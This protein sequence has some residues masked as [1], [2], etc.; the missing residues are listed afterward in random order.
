MASSVTLMAVFTC[1]EKLIA[2]QFPATGKSRAQKNVPVAPVARLAA[3]PGQRLVTIS[4]PREVL[5][6]KPGEVF[7][8]VSKIGQSAT[9]ELTLP[10]KRKKAY[11]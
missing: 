2:L 3:L 8:A 4:A 5:D 11:E 6:M 9:A 10:P 7:A 1:D